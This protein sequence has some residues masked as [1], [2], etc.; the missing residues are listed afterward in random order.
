[1]LAKVLENKQVVFALIFVGLGALL[2]VLNMY[3]GREN[4]TAYKADLEDMARVRDIAKDK[5]QAQDVSQVSV[6]EQQE[7]VMENEDEQYHLLSEYK[8][9]KPEDL[10]PEDDE[11]NAWARANPSGKGSLEFKNFLE[12]GY[13]LG[14]DTQANT[15]RNA[16]L[17]IRS[18]PPNPIKPVSIWQNSTIG[19]D[20]FRKPMEIDGDY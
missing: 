5:Y 7:D 14:V 9:V 15:L 4:Y 3:F 6:E 1:M 13:H 12:A 10:L 11:A 18:E 17:Q 20:P 8:D 19:P 2:Y 16:N